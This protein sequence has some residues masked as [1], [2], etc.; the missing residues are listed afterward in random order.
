MKKLQYLAVTA[1]SILL[2]AG[3]GQKKQEGTEMVSAKDQQKVTERAAMYADVAI[4]VDLSMLTN[5]ERQLISKLIEAGTLV[6]EIFWQQS[7]HDAIA[8]RDSLMA[9]DAASA[10]EFL[11]YV[12]INYGPYDR[13]F[14]GERFVGFGAARKPAGAG[15]YPE[16]MTKEEFEEWVSAHPEQKAALENQYTVVVRDG[17]QLRAVP[18]HQQ[19]PQT[20][21]IA[22]LPTKRRSLPII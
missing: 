12:M 17:D 8:V 13:I 21:K 1:F 16:D 10:K 15:L 20:A 22:K 2:L 7:S 4:D 14:E 9:V 19:Y 6:D 3:C 11:K 5:R 18:Y